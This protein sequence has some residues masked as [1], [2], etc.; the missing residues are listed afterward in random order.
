MEAEH[1]NQIA[2]TAASLTAR[3]AELR[4]FL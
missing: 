3:T 1:L 2:A 4:R